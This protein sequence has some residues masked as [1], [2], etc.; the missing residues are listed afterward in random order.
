[1]S[2][3]APAARA[4]LVSAV[5]RALLAAVASVGGVALSVSTAGAATLESLDGEAGLVE[6][7]HAIDLRIDGAV[8]TVTT[9]LR[10]ENR[11]AGV[12]EARL[13]FALPVDAVVTDLGVTSD[14]AR[15]TRG[16]VVA[17]RAALSP[18]PEP[19][20]APGAPDLALL[21][22]I[23]RDATRATYEVV[24]YPV[25]A[26]RG[27]AV[28]TVVVVPLR[29]DAGR[30]TLRLPARGPGGVP[31]SVTLA[32]TATAGALRLGEVSGNGRLLARN[33]PKV[34]RS[35][36]AAAAEDELVIQ[37]VPSLRGNTP[38]ALVG[39]FPLGGD[40]HGVVAQVLAP[41][42]V[43][44][45]VPRYDRVL[46]VLDVSRSMGA[47]GRQATREVTR[48]V[49][50][51]VGAEAQ[52]EAILFDRVARRALG[53]FSPAAPRPRAQIDQAISDAPLA[54]GSN[55]GAALALA[56]TV[57]GELTQAERAE[58]RIAPRTLL[59]LVDDGLE[60]RA[61]AQ[62]D[63]VV[64]LAD[65]PKLD[66][67]V[68]H[69]VLYPDGAWAPDPLAGAAGA[70]TRR[71]RGR[72][73]AIRAGDAANQAQLLAAELS[74]PAPFA[75][76]RFELDGAEVVALMPPAELAP[77]TG[78]FVTGVVHGKPEKLLLV[79]DGNGQELRVRTV[80]DRALGA[81]ARAL[82]LARVRPDDLALPGGDVG[83]R[84]IVELAALAHAV[85]AETSLVALPPDDGF[86]QDRAA[87]VL[88]WGPHRFQRLVPQPE[89]EPGRGLVAAV[90]APPPERNRAP[91][92]LATQPDPT[93]EVEADLVRRVLRKQLLPRARV[94]YQRALHGGG[95]PPS[96]ALIL[97][98]EL[99][100]GELVAVAI[101][102]SS[103]LHPDLGGCVVDA[104]YELE[105]PR[106]AVGA[107]PDEVVLVRY[108]LIFRVEDRDVSDEAPPPAPP[109]QDPRHGGSPLGLAPHHAAPSPVAAGATRQSSPARWHATR[110]ATLRS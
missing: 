96:G 24:V 42:P 48:A 9:R 18:L 71:A 107:E 89:R 25:P 5:L 27:V 97:E 11:A 17:A 82:F 98:L 106:A 33:A 83:T 93:G 29:Y 81:A 66:L 43:A 80:A 109:P 79:V 56:Q 65:D 58:P 40:T 110:R 75:W 74:R 4:L 30:L 21:R 2:R 13:R 22:M 47:V 14:G 68:V 8:A 26:G 50:G 94:C 76:P 86:A 41:P 72:A 45:E 95:A 55:I 90:I 20:H 64:A 49:L 46:F 73:L 39:T 31:A 88:R 32:A 63:A 44:G 87:F 105:V 23:E 69:V 3:P 103:L 34:L 77:G 52:T 53:G 108:P 36:F 38:R 99:A 91:T 104:A 16:M 59:V 92:A 10:I 6:T 78:F 57:L 54:N 51:I 85:T 67:E 1:M 12:H 35:R 28:R 101:A 61:A 100:R 37:L 60:P 102:A 70:L 7:A 19:E 15:E 62:A 84:G